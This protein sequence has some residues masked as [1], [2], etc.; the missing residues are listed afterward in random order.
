MIG[1][2][3]LLSFKA[4]TFTHIAFCS[5]KTITI[6]HILDLEKNKIES[7]HNIIKV[8]VTDTTN[9]STTAA[10]TLHRVLLWCNNMT[11]NGK[12]VRNPKSC[13]CGCNDN[14]HGIEFSMKSIQP[15]MAQEAP[16]TWTMLELVCTSVRVLT[17]VLLYGTSV[18]QT[19]LTFII[20]ELDKVNC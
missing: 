5:D 10:P 16:W 6:L 13:S 11:W 15:A 19:Q 1:P 4:T 7:N 14:I 3:C 8:S 18:W 20:L 17:S 12:I 2:Y 9:Q